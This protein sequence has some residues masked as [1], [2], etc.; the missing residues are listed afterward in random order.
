MSWASGRWHGNWK[1][2]RAGLFD[3][4]SHQ[5]PSEDFDIIDRLSFQVEPG[6]F[7]CINISQGRLRKESTIFR[8]TNGL[9]ASGR[10][11]R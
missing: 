9:L 8:M 11:H 7:H 1:H 5:Y 3:E 6:S 4:V 2:R 10:D